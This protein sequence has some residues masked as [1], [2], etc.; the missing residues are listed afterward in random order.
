MN[1]NIVCLKKVV[2]EG[3]DGSISISY[4][5]N[6]E[7]KDN[8]SKHFWQFSRVDVKIDD[9]GRFHSVAYGDRCLL[10]PVNVYSV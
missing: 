9:K 7:E 6:I 4:E 1:E 8:L 5:T 2:D 10:E 3:D